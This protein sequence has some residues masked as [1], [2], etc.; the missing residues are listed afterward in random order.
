MFAL[1]VFTP[2]ESAHVVRRAQPR[3]AIAADRSRAVFR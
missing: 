1:D 3:R 2:L